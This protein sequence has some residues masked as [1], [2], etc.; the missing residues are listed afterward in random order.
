MAKVREVIEKLEKIAPLAS[1]EEWDNSGWQVDLGIKNT[2]NILL[3]LN[4]T[5]DTVRQAISQNCDLIISHHPLIFQP[6][7]TI[8]NKVLISAIQNKIQ[9]YSAHTN[10]DK[11]SIGTTQTLVERLKKS[12]ELR[13]VKDLNEFIKV[14]TLKTPLACS[15]F[16]CKLKE[17]LGLKYVKVSRPVAQVKTVAFCAGAGADFA[18]IVKQKNVDCFITADVKY[19]QA[20]DNNLMIVDIGHF[21]SEIISLKSIEK[22]LSPLDVNLVLS[23]EVPIFEI[24]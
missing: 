11:A 18:S 1:Q 2:K 24:V 7:K 14:S 12:L 15:D 21:E 6:L 5:E 20:L 23:N 17:N 10:F 9:I 4:V 16:L 8:K 13:L 19:H 3:A 22:L